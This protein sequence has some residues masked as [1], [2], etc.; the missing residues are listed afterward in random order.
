M[1]GRLKG[2]NSLE[3]LVNY[4]WMI[5]AVAIV[6]SVIFS[7]IGGNDCTLRTSGF[8]P[9]F[10]TVEDQYQYKNESLLL[11][12][13][14]PSEDDI[15]LK[16]IVIQE[17]GEIVGVVDANRR[18]NGESDEKI[19]TNR[20]SSSENCVTRTL[21]I[22]YETSSLD[23]LTA[24]GELT[25]RL[26][27][28][29]I[30]AI[31]DI[32]PGFA[33]A[34]QEIIFNA[35]KSFS[36]ETSI[37]SYNWTFGDGETASGPVVR[38]N[39]SN[40]GIYSVALTIED[41]RGITTR[42]IKQVYIGGILRLRGGEFPGLNVSETVAT[43]CIGDECAEIE[44]EGEDGAKSDSVTLDG[45]LITQEI[46]MQDD[47]L[48]ITSRAAA[49][50]DSGCETRPSSPS[51]TVTTEENEIFGFL[52]TPTIKIQAGELCIGN[53]QTN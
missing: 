37:D 19:Y 7:Q 13:R 4:G 32:R 43:S 44:G 31:F 36:E 46:S 21:T 28:V 14:N 35:S 9:P 6:G 49:G 23:N 8:S 5:I 24:S 53:C 30:R 48:C 15:N 34:D 29:P 25:G 1:L 39:Y 45:S 10:P 51:R 33:E 17:E 47:Y 38:H 27:L 40:E 42:N 22:D 16:E 20:F 18:I 26:G 52:R 50:S 12:V 41:E 3:Y 2:Q 11:N